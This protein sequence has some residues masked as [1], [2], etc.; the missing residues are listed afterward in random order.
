MIFSEQEKRSSIAARNN[1]LVNLNFIE[2]PIRSLVDVEKLNYK[3]GDGFQ[4]AAKGRSNQ[5]AVFFGSAGRSYSLLANTLPS[6]RGQGEPLSGRLNLPAEARVVEVLMGESDQKIILS[7]DAG[8]GFIANLSDLYTKNRNGK[9]ILSL[10]KNAKPLPIQK[11]NNAD[12]DLIVAIS[13]EG[14]ML[15]FPIMDLPQ[16]SKG[17]GNKIINISAARA[18]SREELVAIVFVLPIGN[19][20]M[21]HSGK[22][23]LTLKPGNIADYRG[24]RG[25]RG[26]KLPRGFQKVDQVEMIEPKQMSLME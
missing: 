3:A 9:A 8:Y 12:S 13:N 16:I 14:R 7:S 19:H 5:L 1:I 15:I 24:E 2:I 18:K 20:L 22:R 10:S 26:R 11:V 4:C 6:A 25:R 21:I 17:K 23:S